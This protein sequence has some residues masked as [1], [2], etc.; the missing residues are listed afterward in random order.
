MHGEFERQTLRN[1]V[2][3]GMLAMVFV[4]MTAAPALSKTYRPTRL[5]DPVPGACKPN[6]CSLREAISAANAHVGADIVRVPKGHYRLSL[7]ETGNDDN[8]D[9][10]LD[11]KDEVKISGAG[12]HSTIVDA[13]QVSNVFSFLTFSSHSLSNLTVKG[14]SNPTGDGGGISAGPSRLELTNL[15]VTANTAPYGGG[16]WGVASPLIIQRSTFD[17]NTA[18]ITGGGVDVSPGA[19]AIPKVVIKDSTFTENTAAAGGG[20]ANDGTSIFGGFDDMPGKL[21]MSNSTV[22]L[23]HAT[24]NGGGIETAGGSTSTM[25]NMTVAFNDSDSDSAGGGDGGGIYQASPAAVVVDNSIM[26]A[27][28]AGP[29]GSG[30]QCAGIFSGARNALTTPPGCASF[31][32]GPNAVVAN[33]H[34]GSF[35]SHGGPTQTLSLKPNSAALGVGRDC[36][37]KD[38]RGVKRAH[39]RCDAGA[40]ERP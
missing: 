7:P 38:Q 4:L 39:K 23:N 21:V 29:T 27:N 17:H 12:V 33:L 19:V 40:F 25:R 26:A 18:S 37:A 30:G 10:D 6:D 13:Q 16:Y 8:S 3:A 24:G 9:G 36:P 1:A 14:G 34:L 22:V 15:R 2:A 31:P 28:S 5:D 32:S 11:V 20:V 35:G